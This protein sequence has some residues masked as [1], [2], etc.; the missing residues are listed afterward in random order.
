MIHNARYS[1]CRAVCG[2]V[3]LTLVAMSATAQDATDPF[4]ATKAQFMAAEGFEAQMAIVKSFLADHPNDAHVGDVVEVGATLFIDERD[5][6]PAAV[7]LAEDQLKVSTDAEVVSAI[8]N[9][10]VGLYSNPAYAF[11]LETLV[12]EIYDPATMRFTEHLNVLEAAA[13]AEAWSLVDAQCEAALKKADAETFAADYPDRE[14]S[15]EKIATAG[16][17]REGMILTYVG[18]SAAN[19]GHERKAIGHYEKAESALRPSF[20]G[21]PTNELYRFWGQTLLRRDDVEVGLE[22]LTLAAIYGGDEQAEELARQSL[23]ANRPGETYDDYAWTL[24]REHGPEMVD[25]SATDYQDAPRTFG[26]L[27]GRKATLVAFW[28]PT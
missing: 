24:R 4:E 10:L 22:K 15:D 2:I 12:E 17:N 20:A 18:W 14:F 1:P 19:Q 25:F 7:A 23:A 3:L 26:E 6:R 28:F 9:V 11:K 13:A 5:D 8:Q 27:K 16:K 21:V